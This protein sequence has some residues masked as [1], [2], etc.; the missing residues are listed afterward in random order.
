MKKVKSVPDF[1]ALVVRYRYMK[2]MFNTYRNLV[3]RQDEVIQTMKKINA[4]RNLVN[5]QDEV[6]NQLKKS[7]QLPSQ[8]VTR[9]IISP[10]KIVYS[11]RPNILP[12]PVK[13]EE[14]SLS[15][16]VVKTEEVFQPKSENDT[17]NIPPKLEKN[18]PVFPPKPVSNTEF[19]DCY[20]IAFFSQAVENA[21]NKHYGEHPPPWKKK[22]AV[23]SAQPVKSGWTKR[24]NM[25]NPQPY[26]LTSTPRPK[27]RRSA[28]HSSKP[29]GQTNYSD[30]PIVNCPYVDPTCPGEVVYTPGYYE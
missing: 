29:R 16:L 20:S 25:W 2:M 4:Y 19:E 5:K 14:I 27:Q 23:K 10:H 12:K 24:C 3:N 22:T 13:K 1:G 17:P 30:N 28:K 15:K 11:R 9:H 18:T 8:T 6:I 21:K 26:V 7:C